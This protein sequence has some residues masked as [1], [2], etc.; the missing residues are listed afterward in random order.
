MVNA[1]FG[2]WEAIATATITFAQAGTTG[3]DVDATNFGAFLGPFGGITTPLGQNVIVFDEDGS[4]FDMLFGVGTTVLGFASPT[5]LS[6]G[7]TT[8]PTGATVPP[9]S[10]VIEGLVFLNGKFIDGID[11]PANG[12]REVSQAR[13]DAVFIHEFGHFAGLDHTQ[14]HGL[15]PPPESDRASLTL[16]VETMFPFIVD[17]RQRTLERD[18]VVALSALYPTPDFSASTGKITGQVL[19]SEGTPLSGINV[20]A[21]NIADDSDAVSFVS[22]ATLIPAGAFILHGLTPGAQYRVE[23]Q[24]VDAFHTAGSRVGPFSPPVIMPGPPEFYNGAAESA[25]PQVDDPTVFEPITATAGVTEANIDLVLNTQLLTIANVGLNGEASPI[26]LAVGDFDRDGVLDFVGV[27]IGFNPGNVIRF[28]RGLGDGGFAPPVTIASFPGNRYIVAGQFNP[29]VDDFLDIAIA[30]FTLNQV[31]VYFGNGHGG[32]GPPQTPVD[33]SDLPL[34]AL[35]DLVIGDLNGDAFPDLVTLVKEPD[36]SAT[37]YSLL[38]SA[39]GALSTVTTTLSPG[40]GFPSEAF[41]RFAI[42][43]FAGNSTHDVIGQ[44]TGG[45]GLLIGDGAGGFTAQLIPLSSLP[46]RNL[47]LA[48][49]IGDFDENGTMDVAFN[50]PRPNGAPGRFHSFMEIWLGD[51]TGALTFSHRYRVPERSMSHSVVT[52][53]DRD[54]HLDIASVGAWPSRGSPGAKVTVAFGDGRGGVREQQ[55][56][57]GLHEFP[58]AIAAADL[59]GNGLTDLLLSNMTV[60]VSGVDATYSVLLQDQPPVLTTPSLGSTLTS[61]TMTFT[62]DHTNTD[63]QH[64]LWVGTS[65]G[66]PNLFTQNLGTGHSITVTG[67]PSSGTIYVRYWTRFSDGW[68]FQDHTYTMN[69]VVAQ[70]SILS[71]PPSST[72]TSPTVTFTGDHSNTDLQHWLWVGTSPGSPN[73][74]TRNM[75]T[76]HSMTVNNLP[77]SG[78]IHVRY[79]TRFSNGWRFQDHAYTMTP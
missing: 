69:V 61:A 44:T 31:R 9:G 20:I 18:D 24:E 2:P 57:W 51:G 50:N 1:L 70:P 74:F 72:L 7:V 26:D 19:T 23:V 6:D 71:P 16:P 21:R 68:R 34:S 75:G 5:F 27:Q 13:F 46:S 32:F 38:G 56:T 53:F 42:A 10:K 64:W 43:H 79:W 65:P 39:S 22:G 37:V 3:V 8:V 45:L 17:D 11:D 59:D 14:I 28:F 77:S 47:P 35:K 36:D 30:S 78:P 29:G 55:T 25:D 76:S 49:T 33:R 62:G 48:I 54:G 41:S 40:S 4:I 58:W 63:L 73:L 67:L 12:N 66:S 52:D 60:G 15:H